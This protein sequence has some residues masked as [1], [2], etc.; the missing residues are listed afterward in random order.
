MLLRNKNAV[1]YG[2]GGDIG[3]AVARAFAREGAVVYLAGRNISTLQ[4][5]ANEIKADGGKAFTASVDALDQAA[6]NQHLQEIVDQAHQIDI[7]FNAISI[8]QQGMQGVWMADLQPDDFMLPVVTYSRSNFITA[9]AAA[10]HMI[11]QGSGV[12]LNISATPARLAAPLAGGM[13]TA[14]AAIESISRT[15]AAELGPH[16]IRV[17]CLRANAMPETAMVQ[18]VLNI[19]TQAMGMKDSEEF[20]AAMESGT[21]LRRL[22]AIRE[23]AHTAAFMAS[24]NASAITGAV[25]NLSCGSIAD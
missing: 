9:S 18:N 11:K 2:G 5:V 22:P 1:I 25:I 20:K 8:P 10:R 4:Q 19:F 16:G 14:W 21:M 13:A 7:V 17:V 12:I 3:S 23:I 24:D 6:V 15:L